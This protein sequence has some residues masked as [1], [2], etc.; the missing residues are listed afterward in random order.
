M[1]TKMRMLDR[2]KIMLQG[3][4]YIEDRTMPGW[5]GALP[6]Y[7]FKCPF[8]GIVESYP[9]GHAKMLVCPKCLKEKEKEE[10]IDIA[11]SQWDYITQETITSEN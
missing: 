2:L 5:I 6:F 4:F 7:A 3:Y 1:D 8:H 10:Q 11:L 9:H